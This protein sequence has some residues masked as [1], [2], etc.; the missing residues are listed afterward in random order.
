MTLRRGL[1]FV[2]LCGL[3]ACVSSAVRS[4][5]AGMDA[6]SAPDGHALSAP[7]GD[8]PTE[9]P[10]STC[11]TATELT[12]GVD[13][14]FGVDLPPSGAVFFATTV[15][16]GGRLVV[17]S[18]GG[19]DTYLRLDDACDTTTVLAGSLL[20]REGYPSEA[21]LLWNN[22]DT[23]PRRVI[24]VVERHE[25]RSPAARRVAIAFT[26]AAPNASC[27]GT[28][29]LEPG[30]TLFGQRV[31]RGEQVPHGQDCVPSSSLPSK[32]LWYRVRVPARQT[33]T[34][35]VRAT[36]RPWGR[37]HVQMFRGCGGG[38]LSCGGVS[39]GGDMTA[40]WSDTFG[41]LGDDGGGEVIVSV[42]GD[43]YYYPASFDIVAELSPT[44]PN[45]SCETATVLR[46]GVPARAQY[47][48]GAFSVKP[49]CPGAAANPPLYYAFDV[50]AGQRATAAVHG[51]HSVSLQMI[52]ACAE[53]RC[54]GVA[55]PIAALPAWHNTSASTQRVYF[56]VSEWAGRGSTFDVV[57]RL[58]G[59]MTCAGAPRVG[60]GILQDERLSLADGAG[61]SCLPTGTAGRPTRYYVAHVGAGEQLV[62]EVRPLV[63]YAWSPTLRLVDGCMAPRCL[64]SS[65]SGTPGAD[66]TRLTW[67]NTGAARDVVIL[68]SSRDDSGESF[69]LATS[70]GRPPPRGEA[71]PGACDT[72]TT[73]AVVARAAGDDV[74]AP[75]IALPFT[76]GYFGAA[77][78]AWSASSNGYLQLW[79]AVGVSG[80]ARGDAALPSR[81]APWGMVAP[82][83]DDLDVGAE[84]ASV[85]WQEFT[86][87]ARHVTVEWRDVR[88]C[89]DDSPERLTFQA[90]LFELGAVEFHYCAATASPRARGASASIGMQDAMGLVGTSWAMNREGAATP[91]TG[92]RFAPSM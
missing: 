61:P 51:E 7:D 31:V 47:L 83:W 28:T 10:G 75:S 82:F 15:A 90:K 26:D 5:D 70:I 24:L 40:R 41:D 86:T 77:M 89:C 18:F 43:Y 80:G 33:L 57:A 79:P 32:A 45:A 21:L 78:G 23:E 37:L 59:D 88:P 91:G 8:A 25:D 13:R 62:A 30:V 71:V 87:P 53:P 4:A 29:P 52:S 74:G 84:G 46:D 50:P 3:L 35:R 60:T 2:I 73:P 11:A 42:G 19:D 66:T 22:H 72:L 76:L 68:V 36:G 20:S 44:A 65:D 16:A 17:R 49:V 14:S 81:L 58:H 85:R 56:V 67:T 48:S 9:V 38:I 92:V 27:A 1:L 64:A 6:P 12:P 69:D 34:V 54:L 63:A 55:P 39:S